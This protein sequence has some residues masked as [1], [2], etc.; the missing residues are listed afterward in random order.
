MATEGASGVGEIR[1]DGNKEMTG[2]ESGGNS[3][4]RRNVLWAFFYQ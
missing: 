2:D 3:D 4:K 1:T